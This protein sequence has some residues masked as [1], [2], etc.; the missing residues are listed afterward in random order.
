MALNLFY[1][2]LDL[3]SITFMGI[4]GHHYQVIRCRP[5]IDETFIGRFLKYFVRLLNSIICR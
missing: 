1:M 4:L 2:T 5:K 3:G